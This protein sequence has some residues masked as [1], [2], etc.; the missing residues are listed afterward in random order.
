MFHQHP[1]LLS[2]LSSLCLQ[3]ETLA[4]IYF[5]HYRADSVRKVLR[6]GETETPNLLLVT[7]KEVALVDGNSLQLLWR[8]NTSSVLRWP[9]CLFW[10]CM[11]NLVVDKTNNWLRDTE[12]IILATILSKNATKKHTSSGFSNVNLNSNLVQIRIC[13]QPVLVCLD[14]LKSRL[15]QWQILSS[16]Q[17]CW[18]SNCATMSHFY[19]S[20]TP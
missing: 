5:S 11:S 12:T 15:I 9:F 19:R 20:A 6:V 10:Y 4:D 3:V 17:H 2:S 14:G 16:W 1:F 7:G 18:E 13:G 8:M